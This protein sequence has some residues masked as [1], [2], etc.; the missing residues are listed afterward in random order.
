MTTRKTAT[1]DRLISMR[2]HQDL[3][4]RV[5]ALVPVFAEDSDES[6]RGNS[7][8]SDVLRVLIQIGLS[9]YEGTGKR[10]RRA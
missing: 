5:D 2:L 10:R 8:R 6:P 3:L 9:Q 4:A 7:N 1:E